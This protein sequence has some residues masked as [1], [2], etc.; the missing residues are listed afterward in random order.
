M[1]FMAKC[2]PIWHK[3][4]TGHVLLEFYLFTHAQES[5]ASFKKEKE[6]KKEEGCFIGVTCVPDS[7]SKGSNL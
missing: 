6:K 3:D 1:T 4:V 7:S 2:F 5:H